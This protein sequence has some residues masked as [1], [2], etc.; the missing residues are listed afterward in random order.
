MKKL[1]RELK[2]PRRKVYYVSLPNGERRA[3]YRVRAEKALGR[4]LKS[5]EVVHHHLDDSLV[6]CPNQAY[7]MLIEKR[8]RHLL[9]REKR[10]CAS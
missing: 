6:V 10:K 5:H 4:R 7:H 3:E 1:P 2:K 9:L 8:T